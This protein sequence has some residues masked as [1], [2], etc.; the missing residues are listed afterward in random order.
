MGPGGPGARGG[1]SR[2]EWYKLQNW[3]GFG[4]GRGGIGGGGEESR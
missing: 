1:N 4:G 3:G 2:L